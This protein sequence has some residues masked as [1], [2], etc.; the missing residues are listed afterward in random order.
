MARPEGTD[1]V[2]PSV[3]C[4]PKLHHS[5]FP[6]DERDMFPSFHNK[7][8]LEFKLI[9][10]ITLIRY[11]SVKVERAMDPRAASPWCHFWWPNHWPIT[12][13][14]TYENYGEH[15]KLHRKHGGR[16]LRGL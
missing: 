14:A 13:E 2:A 11:F 9:K 4:T 15:S 3:R 7:K 1:D 8:I 6:P 12:P 5:K 16:I 10:T